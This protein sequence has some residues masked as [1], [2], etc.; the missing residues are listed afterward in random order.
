MIGIFVQTS[1]PAYLWPSH[2][3]LVNAG[4]R[5]P[6]AASG[7][8]TPFNPIG[9]RAGIREADFNSSQDMMSE[10]SVASL[11]SESRHSK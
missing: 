2:N 9:L 1:M 7:V 4:F 3:M 5:R 10:I 8:G 11:S 6:P